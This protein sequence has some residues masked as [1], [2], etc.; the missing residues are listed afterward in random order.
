MQ[1]VC[2]IQVAPKISIRQ[3]ITTTAVNLPERGKRAPDSRC[4]RRLY[5]F[6]C[7][8]KFLTVGTENDSLKA[9]KSRQLCFRVHISHVTHT[10]VEARKVGISARKVMAV[11]P[12]CIS[13]VVVDFTSIFLRCFGF[14]KNSAVFSELAKMMTTHRGYKPYFYLFFF[15]H[16][17]VGVYLGRWVV[18]TCR[19]I[20]DQ[21]CRLWNVTKVA[22]VAV[23]SH[24]RFAGWQVYWLFL[25]ISIRRLFKFKNWL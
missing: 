18:Y 22:R 14:N 23:M 13:F 7:R 6:L 2:N 3:Q 16:I 9:A 25:L 15:L 12:F 20:Q 1:E 8:C 10:P 24:G 17:Y 19:S 4:L 21:G 11:V 5:F